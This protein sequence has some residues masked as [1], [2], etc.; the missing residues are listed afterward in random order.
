M[1]P[2]ACTSSSGTWMMR[3]PGSSTCPW[4]FLLGLPGHPLSRGWRALGA[5]GRKVLPS[6]EKCGRTCWVP[7]GAPACCDRVPD[8]LW[9][10]AAP[11]GCARIPG[12]LDRCLSG[13]DS[14]ISR[15][16]Q[17]TEA[18]GCPSLLPRHRVAAALCKHT[19]VYEQ[20]PVSYSS[21]P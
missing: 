3:S 10:G 13:D 1:N 14:L 9:V 20:N 7:P 17:S 16:D 21:L 2:I 12:E 18:G 4:G 6:P 19:T 15:Q 11:H 5:P 8:G